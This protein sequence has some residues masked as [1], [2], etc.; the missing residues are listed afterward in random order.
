MLSKF[1]PLVHENL[2]G[3]PETREELTDRNRG[4]KLSHLGGLVDHQQNE[5][6]AVRGKGLRNLGALSLWVPCSNL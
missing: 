2:E 4:G 1:L 6:I 5:F 3:T